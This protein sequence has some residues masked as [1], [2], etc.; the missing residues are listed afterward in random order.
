LLGVS[1]EG[2]RK[3]TLTGGPSFY[4]A[5][6]YAQ[7]GEIDTAFEWLD[8]AYKD[9]ELEMYWLKVEPPFEPLHKDPRWQEMLDKVGFPEY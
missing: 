5:M 6:I 9:H 3:E 7:T 8:K 4:L 2:Y 1:I